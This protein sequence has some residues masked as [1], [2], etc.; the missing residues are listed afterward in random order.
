MT[1]PKEGASRL[2]IAQHHGR[3]T[4]SISQDSGEE[5]PKVI[6][7]S[8]DAGSVKHEASDAENVNSPISK[9]NEEVILSKSS[10]ADESAAKEPIRSGTSSHKHNQPK[11]Q[12]QTGASARN[13]GD[14]RERE[15]VGTSVTSLC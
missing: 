8:C 6:S 12:D 13:A 15:Q 7:K 14:R 5:P 11:R 3:C 1:I 2:F 4:E 10:I 9:A